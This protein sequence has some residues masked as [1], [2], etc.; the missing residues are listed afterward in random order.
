[1]PLPI[2]SPKATGFNG[3][4]V[5]GEADFMQSSNVLLAGTTVVAGD[6][7]ALVFCRQFLASAVACHGL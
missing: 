7:T 2:L 4:N 3:R 5:S 1:M 6:A